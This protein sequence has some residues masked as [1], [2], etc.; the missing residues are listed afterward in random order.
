MGSSFGD[1]SLSVVLDPVPHPEPMGITTSDSP[2][3]VSFIMP[4]SMALS[5]TF[6]PHPNCGCPGPQP[7]GRGS[8]ASLF[9]GTTLSL[10][11][12]GGAPATPQFLVLSKG[13]KQ[14]SVWLFDPW[15]SPLQQLPSL[16]PQP[17]SSWCQKLSGKRGCWAGCGGL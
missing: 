13:T 14:A 15:L 9:L 5:A 4:P 12:A 7:Q 11:H 6:T 1:C 2:P 17:P 16:I 10:P 8:Q 3:P